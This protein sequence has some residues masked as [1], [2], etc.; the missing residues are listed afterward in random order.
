MAFR[1]NKRFVMMQNKDLKFILNEMDDEDLLDQFTKRL[2]KGYGLDA[3]LNAKIILEEINTKNQNTNF[4]LSQLDFWEYI[5]KCLNYREKEAIKGKTFPKDPSLGITQIINLV[6][7]VF[8]FYFH[9]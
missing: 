1:G 9:L 7:E 8:I 3:E 6:Q 2:N 5:S 4:K